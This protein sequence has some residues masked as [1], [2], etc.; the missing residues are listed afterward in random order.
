MTLQEEIDTLTTLPLAE[1]IQKIANLAPDLTSTF[2]PKYGYWVTHPNHTGDGNL[3]DLGRIWLNLGSRCH[4]EHA[5]LQTRLIHQSMDDIFFA[6]YGA[7]Y[8]ILKKGLADG[9]IPTPVFDES[10]GCACCRGEPDATILAGFHEN[11]ALYFDM[12]EYRALW[13]DYPFWGG[14]RGLG[15][16]VMLLRLVGSRWRRLLQGLRLGL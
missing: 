12:G 3:N 13:G 6:I 14:G 4:S 10:L 15:R 9:T 16:I 7:T 1:A 11:R 5:P 8:D 2:L